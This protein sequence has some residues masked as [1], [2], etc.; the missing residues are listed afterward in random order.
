LEKSDKNFQNTISKTGI[1][2]IRSAYGTRRRQS[3]SGSNYAGCEQW[4]ETNEKCT[5]KENNNNKKTQA[6]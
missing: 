2:G 5:A 6:K 1:D 4:K 3:M